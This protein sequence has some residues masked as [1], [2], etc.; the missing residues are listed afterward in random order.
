MKIRYVKA[1]AFTGE[2]S[3]G[4]P[5]ACIYLNEAEDLTHDQMLQIAKEHAGFVS[6]MAFCKSEET[7]NADYVV[8]YYSSECEVEFCGHGTIACMYWLIK[9]NS[10]LQNKDTLKISTRKGILTV[11]NDIK[12]QDAVFISAPEPVQLSCRLSRKYIAQEL[13]TLPNNINDDYPI[14]I[15][16]AGLN[17]LI[18]PI[19]T[20]QSEIDILPDRASLE[21][22]VRQND[23]DIIVIFSAETEKE[24]LV[25][26]R[27]FSP[28]FGYLEDPV[29]GS[30]NSALGYYMLKNDIWNGADASIE[31]GAIP[32]HYNIVRIR[33]ITENGI[34]R[35]LFGGKAT[36]RIE[37]E[38]FLYM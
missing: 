19:R 24:H 5:A 12:T 4:N 25:H 35:V 14:D 23:I 34:H 28:K 1:D 15:I 2:L 36:V 29:T 32:E 26:S 31:Q 18:V 9:N 3:A 33:T 8:R 27:V 6:E 11:Y 7:A 21:T 38:Y 37:G 22:F 30:G 17:T 20:L 16:N 10:A 13:R